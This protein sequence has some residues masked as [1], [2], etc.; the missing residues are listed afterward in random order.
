MTDLLNYIMGGLFTLVLGSFGYTYSHIR[1]ETN[2]RK[3]LEEMMVQGQQDI[4]NRIDKLYEIL[5][6]KKTGVD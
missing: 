3:R 6:D 4:V 5:L 1:E 2:D